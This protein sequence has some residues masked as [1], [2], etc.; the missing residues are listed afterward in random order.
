MPP[1]RA[2]RVGGRPWT[3]ATCA[4]RD[5]DL[6]NRAGGVSVAV[7]AAFATDIR[8]SWLL[9][10]FLTGVRI[11]SGDGV[12]SAP[13]PEGRFSTPRTGS[14]GQGRPPIRRDL[15]DAKARRKRTVDQCHA[16]RNAAEWT[17][18]SEATI[19]DHG[20]RADRATPRPPV[21]G[22]CDA[23]A[24]QSVWPPVPAGPPALECESRDRPGSHTANLC[25]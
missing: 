6:L 11:T 4:R 8:I 20:I 7:A 9:T 23:V 17:P 25:R 5:D 24:G 16:G 3:R 15:R 18:A 21:S 12:P 13:A 19:S 2:R 1:L 14:R 22:R 10:R